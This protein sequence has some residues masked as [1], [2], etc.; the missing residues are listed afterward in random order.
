MHFPGITSTFTDL[1]NCVIFFCFSLAEALAL[2]KKH[3]G[4]TNLRLALANTASLSSSVKTIAVCAGS[5]AS[6]IG[7]QNLYLYRSV[8]D[9]NCTGI[10]YSEVLPYRYLYSSSSVMEFLQCCK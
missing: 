4:L 8:A 1:V 10:L 5:G 2:T 3:L 9:P 7:Q 6:V